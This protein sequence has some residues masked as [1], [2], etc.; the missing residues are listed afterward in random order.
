MT[1]YEYGILEGGPM[2]GHKISKEML[3]LNV[4]YGLVPN[5]AGL[6]VNNL[7]FCVY[8][9]IKGT[10]RLN[11]VQCFDTDEEKT[12]WDKSHPQEHDYF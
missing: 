3:G 9:R 1:D 2:D 4:R 12:E 11:F 10:N 5:P 7:K 6:D 8:E